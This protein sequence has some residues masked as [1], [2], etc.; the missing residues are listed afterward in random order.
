MAPGSTESKEISEDST[1]HVQNRK[2]VQKGKEGYEVAK[3]GEH[4][5]KESNLKV[6]L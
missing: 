4:A 1:A 5:W 2:R 3:C 6:H